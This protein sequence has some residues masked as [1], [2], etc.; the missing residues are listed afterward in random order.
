LQK[1]LRLTSRP[2][3]EKFTREFF[4]EFNFEYSDIKL[5]DDYQ[6]QLYGSMEETTLGMLSGGEKIAIAIALRLGLAKALSKGTLELMMLDEP[7]IHLDYQRRRDLISVFK[8]LGV[9]PQMIIVTHDQGLEEA[10]DRVYEVR[11]EKGISKI[12]SQN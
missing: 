11:K 6:I 2:L 10:A 7:T 3:I 4:S 9:I 12:F 8:K 5:D 1:Q